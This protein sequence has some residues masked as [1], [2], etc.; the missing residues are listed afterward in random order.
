MLSFAHWDTQ[1]QE[2]D[3]QTVSF[4]DKNERTP[5]SVCHAACEATL[6]NKGS[7]KTST[8]SKTRVSN[9]STR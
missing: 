5:I 4:N 7:R 1:L 2:V 8:T 3:M 6:G 9:L